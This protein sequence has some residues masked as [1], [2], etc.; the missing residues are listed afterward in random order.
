MLGMLEKAGAAVDRAS[1]R[2]R[3]PSQLVSD[4]LAQA[5]KTFTIYGRDRAKQAAFGVGKRNYNSIA[6]E[7]SWLDSD[8]QRR[9]TTMNDVV[10]AAKLAEMLPDLTI[11]GAMSD[12]HEMDP[13][14]R[15]VEVAAAQLRTTTKPITFWSRRSYA[16][17]LQTAVIGVEGGYKIARGQHTTVAAADTIATGLATV[18]SAVCSF[19]SD[20]SA[21]PTDVSV[22]I[23][24]QA[25][26]PVAGSIIIKTWKTPGIPEAATTFGKKIN[27]IAV[28]V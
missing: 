9:F 10:E 1:G 7:A 15:C 14:Y 21:D 28:G 17:R 8:G 12:P 25:G 5:G 22:T 20:P 24:D 19:D 18:V 26:A 27:W 13:A 6:G 23:G 4:S 16:V 2:V 3:I 11:A